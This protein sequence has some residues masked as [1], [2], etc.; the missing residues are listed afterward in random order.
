[1]RALKNVFKIALIAVILFVI[2][3]ALILAESTGHAIRGL[4]P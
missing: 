2:T 1:M 4:L 3:K